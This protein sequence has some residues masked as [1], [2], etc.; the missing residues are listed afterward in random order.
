MKY[1]LKDVKESKYY[2][3]VVKYVN[4]S[5]PRLKLVFFL[6][7]LMWMTSHVRGCME[8]A[9]RN[10]VFPSPV[11]TAVAVKKDVPIYVESFGTLSSPESVDIRA[12]VTGKIK[13]G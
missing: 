1:S 10:R 9:K 12:Q 7:F 5:K 3:K 2:K 4:S 6:L 11:Q 13:E 8:E